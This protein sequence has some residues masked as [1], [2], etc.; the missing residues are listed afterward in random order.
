MY[1]NSFRAL[2]ALLLA[3]LLAVTAAAYEV[4]SDLEAMTLEDLD[5]VYAVEGDGYR[6]LFRNEEE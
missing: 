5:S 6:L 2:A 4:P 3:A 1:Q